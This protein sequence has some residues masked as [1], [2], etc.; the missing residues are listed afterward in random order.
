MHAN[1]SFDHAVLRV[2]PRVE[3]E[4]FINAGVILFCL[5]RR[6][7]S[8][9]IAFEESRAAALWPSLDIATVRQHLRVVERICAT[10]TFSLAH[11]STQHHSADFAG[12]HWRLFQGKRRLPGSGQPPG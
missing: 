7:L 12:A 3:R 5:E 11:G 4:E 9:R 2:V 8:C 10:R 1:A 6:Y